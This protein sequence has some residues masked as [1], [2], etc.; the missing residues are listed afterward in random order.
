MHNDTPAAPALA[1][2]KTSSR[3]AKLAERAKTAS[4]KLPKQCSTFPTPTEPLC[5][6]STKKTTGAAANVAPAAESP[7]KVP[8]PGVTRHN[9]LGVKDF[10][11]HLSAE[12]VKS[13][14]THGMDQMFGEDAQ[15]AL[16]TLHATN[17]QRRAALREIIIYTFFML[18]FTFFQAKGLL[19]PTFFQFGDA[20]RN[21]LVDAEFLPHHSPNLPKT[22]K[23][24]ATVSDL[25]KWMVG[26][27]ASFV[28]RGGSF[29]D[30]TRGRDAWGGGPAGADGSQPGWA[31]G[32]A[33][34]VG[35]VR[36]SQ[37]RARR[38]DCEDKVWSRFAGRQWPC[39]DGGGSTT[40]A[41]CDLL[42]APL[43]TTAV[44]WSPNANPSPGPDPHPATTC[45][46][47]SGASSRT[48][49][50]SG[51]TTGGRHPGVSRYLYSR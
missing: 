9:T 29:D 11:A 49:R 6:K 42:L 1:V 28:F 4:I 30:Q 51:P 33:R 19:N 48:R 18:V 32:H 26:P 23:E 20:I 12:G 24:T 10:L 35:P 8:R 39:Y 34:F 14:I 41:G 50:P 25:Q 2:S 40:F 47:F 21:Q 7:P 27:L 45:T 16:F 36:I 5:P 15:A 17:R 46:P 31:L 22:F 38:S 3:R 43:C 37:L 13:Q 44:F